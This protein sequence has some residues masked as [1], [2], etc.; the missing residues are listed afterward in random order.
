MNR[1][2]VIVGLLNQHLSSRLR[3]EV[4]S[5]SST[6]VTGQINLTELI[7]DVSARLD[8]LEQQRDTVVS[9]PERNR[10][11][12]DGFEVC[13]VAHARD[14]DERDAPLAFASMR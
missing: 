4:E 6:G 3:V 14:D 5:A 13:W 1:K 2:E 12:Q 11:E 9:L 7:A 10:W 8:E